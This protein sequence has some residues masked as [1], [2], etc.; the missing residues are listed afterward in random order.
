MG[1]VGARRGGNYGNS[2]WHG[3][4]KLSRISVDARRMIDVR[5]EID[6]MAA[7]GRQESVAA[8]KTGHSRQG[9][10]CVAPD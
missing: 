1:E 6:L 7:V 2:I 8:S 5:I 3:Y 9:A 4:W 10:K